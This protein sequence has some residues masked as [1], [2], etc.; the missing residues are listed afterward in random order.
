MLAD[1]L[2]FEAPVF[3]RGALDGDFD[4]VVAV[5]AVDG[6]DGGGQAGLLGAVDRVEQVGLDGRGGGDVPDDDARLFIMVGGRA[7]PIGAEQRDGGVDDL[8][9]VVGRHR[10]V[11]RPV[12]APGGQVVAETARVGEERQAGAAALAGLQLARAGG[13]EVGHGLFQPSEVGDALVGEAAAG[14][15]AFLQGQLVDVDAAL[16]PQLAPDA[17]AGD[18]QEPPRPAL[19]FLRQVPRRAHAVILERRPQPAADAPDLAD[20]QLSQRLLAPLV[21][22][23]QADALVALV[24]L[25]VVGGHLGERLGGGD[26]DGQRD[27]GALADDADN[28]L[29]I[30]AQR[31][32][33]AHA[34]EVEK[35]LVDGVGHERGC[36]LGE[37]RHDAAAHVAIE[38]VVGAEDGHA[39]FLDQL[40]RLVERDAHRD[41]ERLGLVA[42]GDDAPVVVAEHDDGRR[43]QGGVEDPL[44]R[45]VEVIAV[46]QGDHG[47]AFAELGFDVVGEH[48]PDDEVVLL[49]DADR[50][51]LF[52]G[53]DEP[54][55]LP[56]LV[57][58]DP[59]EGELAVDEGDDD[60]AVGRLDALVDDEQVAVVDAAVAH[61]V[62]DGPGVEGG[63]RMAHQFLIE[64]DA[65]RH[66]VL[67]GR[68]ETRPHALIG[69]GDL[70][71]AAQVGGIE[72]EF[73]LLYF[74]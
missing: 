32:A 19:A 12:D 25:A 44:A 56:G 2:L 24:S 52:V 67:R 37:E 49:G 55:A 45:A 43:A 51:V 34:G 42:A 72:L 64:V 1:V 59:L 40:A 17:C 60:I 74:S 15:D 8:L 20:G 36:E 28:P 58:L 5:A 4:R 61:G 11:D 53:G 33:A 69:V 50:L 10:Q 6:V 3:G 30:V 29:A 23:D 54:E 18:G 31:L 41:A 46:G 73:H 13:G 39:V 27:A 35:G 7:V 47:S 57:Y 26:A 48:A 22:V 38:V 70:E 65:V 14:A 71:H 68:R 16:A 66:V 62:A 63:G 9:L 21:G